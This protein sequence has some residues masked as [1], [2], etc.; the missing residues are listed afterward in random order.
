M[1]TVTG[2]FQSLADA[3][4]SIQDLRMAGIP[5]EEIFVATDGA[6]CVRN[7]GAVR[8]HLSDLLPADVR[9][10]PVQPA[11]VAA[12]IFGA[13][14]AVGSLAAYGF[15]FS[16]RGLAIFAGMTAAGL[17]F[18]AGAGTIVARF[19]RMGKTHEDEAFSA[20]AD[21]EQGIVVA[22]HVSEDTQARA[23]SILSAHVGSKVRVDF[24][25]WVAS[26]WTGPHPADH[27]YPLESSYNPREMWG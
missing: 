27:L 7:P 15:P 13:V 3:N 24:D 17:I 12:A 14:A 26:G 16:L 9:I 1:T 8:P 23:M 20:E 22:A 10:A 18:G 21:R 4:A 5:G 2:V 19:F 6:H 25:P 11:V